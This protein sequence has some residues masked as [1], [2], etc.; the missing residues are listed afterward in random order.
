MDSGPESESESG[1][2]VKRAAAARFLRYASVGALATAVHYSVLVGLVESGSMA[3]RFAAAIG[4]WV[5]AQ[6]AFVG[7]AWFTF[8]GAQMH[9]RSWI[10]FQVTA[11]I[12]AAISFAI[13]AAGVRLG[14]HYLL[15]QAVA[16]LLTLFVTYE[17][18]RRWSFATPGPR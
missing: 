10:R 16:T 15:A 6:V 4:A 1:N 17:I 7:N 2:A 13:V 12:G 14:L 9:V 11:V 3:P 5:G 8:D 18:N